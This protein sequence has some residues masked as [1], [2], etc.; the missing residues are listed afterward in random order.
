[1]LCVKARGA[2]FGALPSP[3][4]SPRRGSFSSAVFVVSPPARHVC[5]VKAADFTPKSLNK[6]KIASFRRKVKPSH[7][8]RLF[9][10][11]YTLVVTL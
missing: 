8:R 1:M 9:S 11:G 10:M 7:A 3:S 5:Q 6:R 2:L 4:S